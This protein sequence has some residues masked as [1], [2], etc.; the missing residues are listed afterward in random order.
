MMATVCGLMLWKFSFG[1]AWRNASYDYSLRFGARAVTN[2]IAY[3]MMDTEAYNQFH[4]TRD[5]PWD[6]GLHAQLL[7]KLADDQCAMVVMD[8]FFRDATEK[9]G[10]LANAMRRLRRIALMAQQT[11]ITSSSLVGA[12][13]LLPTELLCSAAGTN[14]GVAWFASD[15]DSVVRRHW[16]F[17]SPGPYPSLPETA[18]RLAGAQLS[19]APQEKWLRYYGQDGGWTSLSYGFALAKPA[20]FFRDQIVFVG[21]HPNTSV[22]NGETDKFCTPYY[23]WTKEASGGTEILLTSFLNLLN[24]EWLRRPAAWLEALLLVATGSLLGAGLCRVNSVTA[25]LIAVVSALVVMLGAVTISY[26][27]NYWFPWLVVAGGQ[28]PCAL[29]WSWAVAL[30]KRLTESRR[31]AEM[32][33]ELP[34]IPGYKLV[35]P[36]FGRGAYGRVWLGRNAAGQWRAVKAVYLANFE[37]DVSPYDREFNGISKYMLI[38]DKHP[39][40]LRLDFVSQKMERYFYYVME[41]GDSVTPGWEKA[42]TSYKPRDLA[43]A[44]AQLPGRKMPARDCV[45]IGIELSEVLDFLHRQGLTHRDI[46]PPNVIFVNGKPKLADLGLVAEIRPSDQQRTAVGTPG[47]MPPPPETPGTPQADIYALGIMLYVLNTG[48][49]PSFFPE[50][51]TTLSQPQNLEEFMALN[52]VILKACQPDP[53]LRYASAAEMRQVLLEAQK[54]LESSAP[55]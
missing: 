4:Q 46:K 50:I 28:V 2:R 42:P 27:S 15:D 51:S 20:N 41:L 24:G 3:I 29:V 19:D 12:H 40:L 35:N 11:K 47:Y 37:N 52:I 18:A 33:V 23:R 36:P 32:A 31:P 43:S 39:G 22:A 55:S 30:G 17:P 21:S 16:P 45:R 49:E 7:N 34:D 8:C 6:R 14:W 10:A 26:F 54:V 5:R 53:N 38:S 48:R 13:P 9:D 44:R 25:S 1:E